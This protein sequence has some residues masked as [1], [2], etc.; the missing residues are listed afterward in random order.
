MAEK[1]APSRRSGRWTFKRMALGLLIALLIYAALSMLGAAVIFRAVFGRSERGALSVEL[2]YADLDA[3]L[4][5]R[6]ALRF[7]SGKNTLQGY[8]YGADGGPG[9]VVVAHGLAGGADSH[10]AE[11]KY[12]LDQGWRVFCFDGTGTR[13]S[14]GRGTRGL[15]QMKL[16]LR[17]AI[18]FLEAEYPE[19]PLLLYGHSMGAYAAAT[20][21]N[22]CPEIR[23]AVCVSCFDSPVE[24]MYYHSRR[25]VGALAATGYPFLVLWNRLLFGAEANES[26]AAAI[27]ETEV[28]VL[29]VQGSRDETVPEAISLFSRSEALRDP[30]AETLLVEQEPR[31]RHSTVWLS[32]ESADYYLRKRQEADL[33]RRGG[34]TAEEKAR[35][36]EDL[37]YDRLYRLDEEVMDRIQRFFL[38]AAA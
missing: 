14:E 27:S 35:F 32:A 4:Y 3:E 34:V 22:D 7:A 30:N 19:A 37:D 36:Y 29:V 33:L 11:T 28:P 5:P 24:T 10:L 1:T 6:Q 31:N 21:L 2:R 18:R 26:A 13:E 23:A 16:D 17:A 38:R 20:V 12:F 25:R 9:I 15:S 8:L